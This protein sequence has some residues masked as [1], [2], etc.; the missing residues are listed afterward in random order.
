[1]IGDVQLQSTP[2]GRLI[3]GDQVTITLD[4]AHQLRRNVYDGR[5]TVE[6]ALEATLEY[7][8]KHRSR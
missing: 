1:M 5:K 7:A 2:D 8:R 3:V 4:W 6:R